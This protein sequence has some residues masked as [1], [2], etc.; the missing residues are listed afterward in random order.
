MSDFQITG[1]SSG[2][3]WGNIIDTMMEKKRAVETQWY[4]EQEKLDTKALLYE[5]LATNLSGLQ[6]SLDPLKRESTFLSKSVAVTPTAGTA[7]PVAVSASPE[8]EI[9]RFNVDVTSV[10]ANHRVAGNR[11]DDADAAL[12]LEGSFDLSVGDFSVT[13]DVSSD[14]SLKDVAE[15]INAAIT[16]QA[17]EAEIA[18]PLSAQVLDNTL[19]LE[20]EQTGSENA[21]SVTDTDGLL[22]NL[23]IVD[24]TGDYTNVLQEPADAQITLDGLDV[25][26]SSNTIDDL[27]EGVSIEVTAPG[28]AQVDVSL[29]AEAAVTG[30]KGMLEAYNQTLDWVNI[31]LTEESDEDP[32]SDV[33]KKWGLLKGD[34]LLW[35]C[36]QDM[37]SIT[38]KIRYDLEGEYKSLSS[39]GITTESVDYGKS[40]KLEFDESAFMDAMLDDPEGVQK[41]LQSFAEEMQ[42]FTKQMISGAP[43]SVG[44][45]MVKTGTVIN[46]I[47][48]LEK[49]SSQIDERIADFEARLEMEQASLEKLYAN[50]E[51]RLSEMNQQS[52]HFS[53][54]LDQGMSDSSK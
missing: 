40:G 6:G 38:S 12:G 35:S 29:D 50:M 24:G 11:Y 53:A 43:E 44:G 33:E 26:R 37:R 49:R 54:L 47:D 31:R 39:V 22:V 7:E 13:V 19:I 3:D 48:S 32:E 1:L 51:T 42:G 9:G 25:T 5:E 52:Y 34:D 15:T 4:E 2:I 46:R 21:L 8:A 17:E 28:S 36:K 45:S 10:A 14:Q 16:Q 18:P 23:G 41:V 20:A 27:I 30:V